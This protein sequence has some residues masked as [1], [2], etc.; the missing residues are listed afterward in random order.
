MTFSKELQTKIDFA[1]A[2]MSPIKLGSI[3]FASPLLLAPMSAICNAPFRRLMEELGAGGT[4]SE[5][6]SCHGINHGNERTRNM[7]KLDEREKNIGLQLFGEDAQ[8]MAQA[9]Q[10]A[11]DHGPKFIDIN[12]GCPVKKVVSKGGGS[13]LLKETAKLGHFFS[14]IKKSLEIPLTIKI[15]TGWDQDSLNADEV[16]HIAKEE[17]VE[18]VAVHGRTRTQQYTGE[19]NWEYLENLAQISPLPLIGNGDLHSASSVQKRLEQ[20]HCPALMLG[21]GP[22]RD[23]FIFLDSFLKPSDE[24]RFCAADYLETIE[25]LFEYMQ[26]HVENDRTL[27]IQMRKHIMW[28][29][30]GFDGVTHFRRGLFAHE[31]VNDTLT[32]TQEYFHDLALRGQD[33]KKI[34]LTQ[35]FMTSGHG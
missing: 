33:Y 34:D 6:I 7:L 31:N 1:K 2:R 19:A 11:Q 10:V 3:E 23:P 8:S 28:F 21:R 35:A 22:L 15:R 18:F 9:A 30:A 24:I 20:T 13:A 16:I 29:A 4:V 27:V 32:Y 26:G 25:K 14:T 17:G 5:L 12:M